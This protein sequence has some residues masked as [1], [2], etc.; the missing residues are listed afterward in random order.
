MRIRYLFALI[1]LCVT[2]GCATV[3]VPNNWTHVSRVSS[4][5][6]EDLWHH[7]FYATRR[8]KTINHCISVVGI[9]RE[10][11]QSDDGDLIIELETDPRLVNAANEHG[12]LRLEA[13]CQIRGAKRKH[14][15]A[16]RGF[17]GPWFS[18]PTVGS[19]V[20]AI[21]RYVGDRRHGGHMEIHPLSRLE[22]LN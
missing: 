1:A 2:S 9:V 20:R 6:D 3:H 13:V 19:T 18:P 16:C 21:G 12:W 11:H 17:N 10:T 8:L 15:R 14:R 7:T 4:D 22:Q 5:C